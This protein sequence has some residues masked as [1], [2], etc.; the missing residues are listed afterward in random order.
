M[1]VDEALESAPNPQPTKQA[2]G[3]GQAMN[4]S[5]VCNELYQLARSQP[6][7][8]VARSYNGHPVLLV[9]DPADAQHILRQN[10]DNW[11]KN[12]AWLRQ[13]MGKSRV[14]ENDEAWLLRRG[15]TQPAFNRYDVALTVASSQQALREL[16][17]TLME[18]TQATG[19]LPDMLLRRMTVQIM[20]RVLLDTTL[21][22]AEIQPEYLLALL[23][24]GSEFAF[25]PPGQLDD[26]ARRQRIAQLNAAKS[27]VMRDLAVFRQPPLSAKSV[28]RELLAME[29]QTAGSADHVVME[30]EL[31][32]LFAAGSETNAASFGWACHLLAQ[33]PDLQE[34]LRTDVQAAL[35][36]EGVQPGP[37]MALHSLPVL[38]QLDDFISETLRL[39]PPTPILSR[40]AR[41]ADQLSCGPVAP[42]TI[43]LISLIGLHTDTRWR[44]APWSL[45]L[46]AARAH[47]N[48]LGS[49][50][51]SAFGMGE[52]ACGGRLFAM[53]ELRALLVQLL[54]SA[55]IEAIA[56]EPLNEAIDVEWR[57]QMIRRGGQRL[58][59]LPL[60]S[61]STTLP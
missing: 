39:F 7:Q 34:Q 3:A 27:R 25:V 49:G 13:A 32:T 23:D 33:H 51:G 58:R 2:D 56:P 36:A 46:A 37:D 48:R 43:V 55:R 17:P 60:T 22:E 59:V 1:A 18:T 42:G 8:T 20:T 52:R 44:E 50:L 9:Q 53:T 41:A 21:E 4:S 11:P 15:L 5:G 61:P 54:C 10:V 14:S 47:H 38:P 57:S 6:G 31:I 40:Y 45:D 30:Q 29:A 19:R 28:V 16:L 26:R 12:M 35:V 24:L